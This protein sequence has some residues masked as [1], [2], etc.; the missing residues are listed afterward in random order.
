MAEAEKQIIEVNGVKLE[1]DMRHAKRIEELR[2]GSKVKVLDSRGYGSAEVN[3]GVVVGFEPFPSRPTIIIAFVRGSWNEAKLEL[4]HFNSG[5][6]KVEIVAS[7]DEDFSVNRDEVLG[8]FT[9]ER[10]SLKNKMAEL[11]AKEAFFRDRF[12]TY[13]KDEE[14]L[15]VAEPESA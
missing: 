5:T 7:T 11:D 1:V 3:P 14:V 8:W 13:W 12:K 9:R 6:E 2:V 10:E 15:P 4:L